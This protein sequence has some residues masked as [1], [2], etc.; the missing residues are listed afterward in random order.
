MMRRKFYIASE[1]EI[2]A[3]RITD[4]YFERTKAILKKKGLE[5]VKVRME[6]HT[7]SLPSGYR[8]AVY[9]GLEEALNLLEGKPL[10]VYSLPEGTLITENFPIMIIEGNYMDMCV[11][12]T[13]L[14]GILRHY[15][16]VATRAAR[17]KKLAG[18][19]TVLYFGLRG[20]H[21]AIS[22]MLD[23]AAYIGGVDG[24]SGAFNEETIGVTPKGTM[25]HAL[26]LVF[27]DEVKAWLAY[28]EVV[29][30]GV[31][32]IALVDTFNDERF[33]TIEA[34]NALGE[35]LS[36]VRLDTPRSRRGSMRAII[37]EIRWTLKLVG[38][39]NLQIFVSGG[40][41]E[42][43]LAQLRDVVDGFGVGT[44]IT[45]PPSVDMSMDIVEKKIDGEWI[46][47]AKRGKLP[48]AKKVYRCG[49]LD[50]EITSFNAKP[51][52]CSENLMVRWMEKGKI[53]RDLPP[54]EEI[55][56]YVVDQLKEA[57]GVEPS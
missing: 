42:K 35:K 39:E 11:Y 52:R 37:E 48:A 53:I 56:E 57:P 22:P 32:R 31:P 28:D 21:P 43:A 13:P 10:D 38:R 23:R 3:G 27:G 12:E 17:F 40:L 4:I 16:S 34:V 5:D 41:S 36:G 50:Y 47:Y 46:P 33:A 25:P 26:I 54:I 19:K 6:I 8:W 49:V 20:A 9:V 1:E 18:E 55:R 7:G 14:L 51:L 2:K 15:T 30:K 44:S 45:Y 24:V 29:D